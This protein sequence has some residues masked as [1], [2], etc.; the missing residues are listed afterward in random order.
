LLSK[1]LKIFSKNFLVLQPLVFQVVEAVFERTVNNFDEKKLLKN[2]PVSKMA[3][4]LHRFSPL[5]WR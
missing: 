2:L 3:V 1:K 4:P 5:V